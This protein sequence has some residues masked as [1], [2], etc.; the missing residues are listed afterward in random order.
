MSLDRDCECL[1]VD[2]GTKKTKKK[3]QSNKQ[4]KKREKKG[5]NKA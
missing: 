3:N 1:D 5:R 4:L 2:N